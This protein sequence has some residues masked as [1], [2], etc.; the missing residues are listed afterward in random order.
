MQWTQLVSLG[1]VGLVAVL[2]LAAAFE[3]GRTTLA[4]SSYAVV[5]GIGLAVLIVVVA[6]AV[7]VGAKNRQWIHNPDSYW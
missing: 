7:A 6:L 4:S 3:I 1:F 5:S 2:S